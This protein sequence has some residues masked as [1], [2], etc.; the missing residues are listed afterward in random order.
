M[1]KRKLTRRQAWRVEKI[2]QERAER[3]SRR[4][5]AV[6]EQLE[7]GDLGHEQHG[8]IISHFGRQV[9]VES[10]DGDEPGSLHR[11]HM[12]TNLGQ[13]VT[14]DRVIWRPASEGGVVVAQLE[15]HSELMRPNPQGELRPVAANI[16]FIV[17]TVAVEPTPYA[18]LIDR[19]LVAAELS[20][21][22]PVILLNKTDLLTDAN[23]DEILG[24]LDQ[25]QRIGY[26]VLHASTA[27]TH[28]LDALKQLLN[29]RISVFVGQS[30]VGKSSLINALLPGVDLRVGELSAQ[31]RKGRHT[32]TT[33]RLFHF[34][35]GGDLIDSPGIREFG[36]WHLE[37]ERLI[38][39]FREFRPYLGHCRFRDCRHEQEPGCAI[40][41]AI[42]QNEI[43]ASRVRSYQ[44][45]RQSLLTE[46]SPH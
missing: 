19:Y 16:D 23:R 4:D 8:L 22:E 2:Q 45:I 39:G 34:P 11:C 26:R 30:G 28:G 43:S 17:V 42:E 27:S 35:D 31:T 32:T 15:R 33:A 14:G 37:P 44:H 9:D 13:L 12:R 24:M 3:A 41:A 5:Q 1:S 6:D 36:L 46:K 10:L 21:I 38:E 29:D 20:G 25:Y 40:K 18:N 7:G